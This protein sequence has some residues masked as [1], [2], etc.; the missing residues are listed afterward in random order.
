[1][2]VAL[3]VVVVVVVLAVVVVALAVLG[4]LARVLAAHT[5]CLHL[6]E[7]NGV[8]C[9]DLNTALISLSKSSSF[10]SFVSLVRSHSHTSA[11]ALLQVPPPD[12]EARADI[13]RLLLRRQQHS[14]EVLVELCR[15]LVS[16]S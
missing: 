1:M 3:V 6:L 14:A 16:L 11:L 4:P 8:L 12:E 7:S 13:L 10:F 5:F 15:A 9:V 2:L